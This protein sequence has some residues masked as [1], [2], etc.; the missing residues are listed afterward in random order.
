M[1]SRYS[2]VRCQIPKSLRSQS[3][4]AYL[5][6][7][8]SIPE[9]SNLVSS[10]NLSSSQQLELLPS[11]SKVKLLLKPLFSFSKIHSMPSD[12]ASFPGNSVPL[13]RKSQVAPQILEH[14]Q[15]S[16]SSYNPPPPLYAPGYVGAIPGYQHT[17]IVPHDCTHVHSLISE[18]LIKNRKKEVCQSSD[19]RQLEH[20]T[21]KRKAISY[22]DDKCRAPKAHLDIKQDLEKPAS[23]KAFYPAESSFGSLS[24]ST[25]PAPRSFYAH[26]LA[27][28][29]SKIS[30]KH[31][32]KSEARQ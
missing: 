2:R 22:D 11:T 8:L 29:E 16:S 24:N 20:P 15:S 4:R 30:R 32:P 10:S 27:H 18:W 12:S 21:L 3:V 9:A 26:R 28:A 17:A 31:N 14:G 1:A 7:F 23:S 5:L 25:L 13:T 6:P 19:G